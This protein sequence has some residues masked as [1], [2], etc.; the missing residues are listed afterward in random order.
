MKA[1]YRPTY[2]PPADLEIRDIPIPTPGDQQILVEVQA[3][4]VSRTDCAILTGKPF[5]IRFFSG[6]SKPSSPIPGTD[7]AGVVKQVGAKV[8]GYAVGDRVMGFCDNGLGTQAQYI[9]VSTKHAIVKIPDQIA[10]E[11]AAASMEGAHYAINFINKVK[12][13]PGQKVMVNG[14]TGGIGSAAIQLL[15]YYGLNVTATAATQN[16]PLVTALGA[17]R[18]IDYTTTDFTQDSETFSFVFDAVGKSSFEKCKR[19]LINGGVYVSSELGPKNENPWL[20]IITPIFG[21]KKV[22]FPFPQNIQS[23]LNFVLKLLESGQYK[24]LIDKTYPLEQ[25]KEAYRYAAS[26]QKLGNVIISYW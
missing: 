17:D 25:I 24:P 23:S 9:L 11:Q 1:A 8:V 16:I 15:K 2:C 10:F 22:I 26:G 3:T 18:V 5:V 14:G 6:L 7:F 13:Q 12:L 19:L 4:T 20:A 21:N